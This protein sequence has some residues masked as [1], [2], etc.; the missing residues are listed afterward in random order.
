MRAITKKGN[1]VMTDVGINDKR[2]LL[3]SYYQDIVRY[4]GKFG[5]ERE[6]LSDAINETFAIAFHSMDDLREVDSAKNWL[7][8]IAR[9]TGLKAKRKYEKIAIIECAFE[10]DMVQ[11]SSEYTPEDDVLETII[12]AADIR[13]LHDCL[14][15]LS[16]RERRVLSLQYEYDEKLKDIAVMIGETLNNTKSISRRAKL[17]LKDLLI[18]GGYEHGK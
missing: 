5:L 16:E 3:M 6:V 10:E 4:L 13:L 1:L 8:A 2:K 15:K 11:L 12:M 18:D 9:T 7:I 17:K 14:M